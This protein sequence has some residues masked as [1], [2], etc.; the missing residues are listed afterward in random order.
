MW[1]RRQR[2][3]RAEIAAATRAVAQS[4]ARADKDLAAEIAAAG[5]GRHLAAS[6]RQ[7]REENHF[8]DVIAAAFR[9]PEVKQ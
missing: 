7:M 3:D 8:K 1:Y 2:A 5:P 9:D 6:L 4:S